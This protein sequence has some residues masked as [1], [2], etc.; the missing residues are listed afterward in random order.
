MSRSK[1][2]FPASGNC[3]VSDKKSKQFANRSFRNI[4]KVILNRDLSSDN[5]KLYFEICKIWSYQK[6]GR[7][8]F[9]EKRSDWTKE[10]IKK[11]MRK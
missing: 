11:G 4:N 10:D 9:G 7:Q 5:L 6:D 1:K 2:K 8:Y 3:G